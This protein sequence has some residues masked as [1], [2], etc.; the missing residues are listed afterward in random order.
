MK[1]DRVARGLNA[2]LGQCRFGL[3]RPCLCLGECRLRGSRYRRLSCRQP[4]RLVG[5]PSFLR[6]GEGRF[7]FFLPM[8]PRRVDAL[9]RA[10]FAIREALLA[11]LDRRAA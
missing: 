7:R 10:P 6:L 5:F 3:L 11:Y 8:R 2:R 9:L 4:R 1:L